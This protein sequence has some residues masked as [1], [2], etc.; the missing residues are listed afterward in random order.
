MSAV[1][2]E[3]NTNWY[4][5]AFTQLQ[6][7]RERAHRKPFC[8]YE[9]QYDYLY[10]EN[11]QD[12]TQIMATPLSKHSS[13]IMNTIN[14]TL[15][16]PT[17]HPQDMV[18][19]HLVRSKVQ[20]E[21]SYIKDGKGLRRPI[22]GELID[23]SFPLPT[24]FRIPNFIQN[25]DKWIANYT[26]KLSDDE[27]LHFKAESIDGIA[28]DLYEVLFGQNIRPW[29]DVKYKKRINRLFFLSIAN[30]MNT[31]GL[32]NDNTANYVTLVRENIVAPLGKLYPLD[33][34]QSSE[35]LLK[36]SEALRAIAEDSTEMATVNGILKGILESASNALLKDPKDDDEAQ[37]KALLNIL[38]NNLD[39]LLKLAKMQPRTI[40]LEKVY[41][42]PIENLL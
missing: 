15:K 8:V 17:K 32:G 24:D 22:G 6:L 26:L 27:V 11:P 19:F 9:G 39:I 42:A 37:L 14:R 25:Y 21:M 34:Q 31:W 30:M 3:A 23:V 28:V 5:A 4:H 7:L 40:K 36:I 38:D 20:F 13:W 35:L 1:S 33:N 12:K 41:D 2:D 18:A 16:W 29:D 10:E